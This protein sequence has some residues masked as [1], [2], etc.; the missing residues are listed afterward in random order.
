M[1]HFLAAAAIGAV[2]AVVGFI[3]FDLVFRRRFTWRDVVAAGVGGAVAS[4]I[5]TAMFG[6]GG[7]A[8]A[9]MARAATGL[10][11]S[12]AAGGASTQMTSNGL[13]HKPL[14][15]GVAKSAALGAAGS[16]VS[17]GVMKYG[18]GPIVLRHFPKLGPVL[19]LGPAPH[20]APTAA[21][22][23]HAPVAPAPTATAPAAS[24]AVPPPPTGPPQAGLIKGLG[25][26]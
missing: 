6:T 7:L 1:I 2:M 24:T 12:G 18:L 19:G 3:A 13:E 15:R 8:A 17:G 22:P 10:I 26:P 23:V 5:S 21:P 4:V 9:S 16:V 20:P 14:A 11:A 25:G